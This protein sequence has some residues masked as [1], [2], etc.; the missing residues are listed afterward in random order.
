MTKAQAAATAPAVD[1]AAELRRF[2]L[3]A[4]I[5][6]VAKDQ[7][8][9]IDEAVALRVQMS[10]EQTQ[11]PLSVTVR[12]IEPQGKLLGFASVNVGG[13]VVDDFKVV[14]GKNGMFLSPPSKEAPGTR[15]GYRSTARVTDR[16]LQERLDA[17]TRDAYAQAVEKLI[18][19]VEALRPAPIKE[20]MAQAAK[21]AEKHNASRTAPARE[22]EG[23]DDR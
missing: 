23:H 3:E 20:Q 13:I 14:D 17:L 10:M 5:A 8:I 21:E 9:S 16:A 4:P 11:V 15:S 6:E 18:A 1:E 22:K 2:L 7:G 12:P 19:R